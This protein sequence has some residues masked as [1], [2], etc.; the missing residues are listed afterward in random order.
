MTIIKAQKIKDLTNGPWSQLDVQF[1]IMKKYKEV[2]G[3]LTPDAKEKVKQY[4]ALLTS[5]VG[6]FVARIA[7]D[8]EHITDKAFWADD[9]NTLPFAL[10][11]TAIFSH[12]PSEEDYS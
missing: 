7:A 5:D 8:V 11:H 12:A 3:E 1:S 2:E 10:M 4:Y 9:N 6:G